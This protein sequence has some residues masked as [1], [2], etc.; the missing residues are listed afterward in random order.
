MKGVHGVE[1]LDEKQYEVL[2]P[3]LNAIDGH[4]Q[5]VKELTQ[6]ETKGAQSERQLSLLVHQHVLDAKEAAGF[7]KQRLESSHNAIESFAMEH[8]DSPLVRTR[9]NLL[10]HEQQRF[11][12]VL[13]DFK[14]SL[15]AF[16]QALT[17]RTRREL[18]TLGFDEAQIDD[19]VRHG[20]VKELAKR[21]PNPNANANANGNGNG[22]SPPQILDQLSDIAA[23]DS[24]VR[25]LDR[26]A[27]EI[28]KLYFEL[29]HASSTVAVRLAAATEES[30]H[31][32]VIG[33]KRGPRKSE[34]ELLF[35]K[36]AKTRQLVVFSIFLGLALVIVLPMI[37]TLM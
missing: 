11:H 33:S 14:Q 9:Q 30:I 5:K 31:G 10:F 19:A 25:Q 36:R 15:E 35:E 12:V 8:R 22:G 32:A 4:T 17:D 23:R 2:K 34:A 26:S 6:Q 7:I 1:E 37:F 20:R 13:S 28:H 21:L 27:T 29:S 18:H 16:S 24:D 3:K